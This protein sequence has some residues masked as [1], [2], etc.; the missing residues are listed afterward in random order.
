MYNVCY[1]A[2]AT[3]RYERL[4][5]ANFRCPAMVPHSVTFAPSTHARL[6]VISQTMGVSRPIASIL[7]SLAPGRGGGS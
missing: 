2:Y 7:A 5:F 3:P 6:L 4:V 1:A